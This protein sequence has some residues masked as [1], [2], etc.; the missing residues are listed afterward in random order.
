MCGIY[1]G[2][3]WYIWMGG[4]TGPKSYW[5]EGRIGHMSGRGVGPMSQCIMIT[6]GP[7]LD[8][9]TDGQTFMKTLPSQTSFAGGNNIYTEWNTVDMQNQ[10][11]S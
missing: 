9:M 10:L 11:Y 2:Y 7:P 1:G 3:V 6:W 5:G 8:R 4:E